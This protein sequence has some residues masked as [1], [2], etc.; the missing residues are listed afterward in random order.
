MDEDR[1]LARIAAGQRGLVTLDDV[2]RSGLTDRQ[3]RHRIRQGRLVTVRRGVLA[4]HGTP[5]SW[6]QEVL[7]ACL[8]VGPAAIVSHDTAAALHRFPGWRRPDVLEL[9]VPYPLHPRLPGVRAHRISTVSA[10]DITSVDGLPATTAARTVCDL[11]GRLKADQLGPLIDDL[12]RHR[13]MGMAELRRCV[14]RLREAR[15]RRSLVALGL[16][17]DERTGGHQP[18]DSEPELRVGRLLVAAGMPP[19]VQQ[20]EVVIEG[21]RYRLDLAYPDLRIDIEYEGWDGHS[22]RT[23]L[24]RDRARTNALTGAGWDVRFVT[25]AMSDAQIV[26][27]IQRA[28]RR[29]R[30]RKA[31]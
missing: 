20:Y 31:A 21:R 29:A 26:A 8:A 2:T 22:T 19:A 12:L 17:V 30:T 13:L 14:G 5:R 27:D 18:G 23:D 25:A 7:A 9:T 16:V 24:V 6:E 11:A 4:V 1:T 3:L 15:V 10:L 28:I